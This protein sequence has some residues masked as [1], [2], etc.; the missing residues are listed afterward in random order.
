MSGIGL[1]TGSDGA[2]PRARRRTWAKSLGA[3]TLAAAAGLGVQ[4]VAAED[5]PPGPPGAAHD[6]PRFEDGVIHHSA[7]YAERIGLRVE[8]AH[9]RTLAPTTEVTGAVQRSPA[10]TAAVGALIF[11]RVR[12]VE[13]VVGQAVAAGQPLATLESAE[14][15]RAQAELAAARARTRLA[16]AEHRRKQQLVD[17]GIAAHRSVDVTGREL[18]AA[19]AFL[20]ASKQRVHA[21]LGQG[22]GQQ[23]DQQADQGGADAALGEL[24]LRTPIAGEVIAANV[25]LGQPVE[26]DE[27]AFEVADLRHLWLELAVFTND[28]PLI[29]EGDDVLVQPHGDEE[30]S[31]RGHV[32]HV[33]S[34]IDPVSRTAT[35]RV[36]VDDMARALRVGQ[37]VRAR[38]VSRGA[39]VRALA[40]P[41]HA[42]VL[43]DGAPTVFVSPAEGQV[44]PR[45]VALG[46]HGP[47]HVEVREGLRPG[48]RVVVDG[49]FELKSELFR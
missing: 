8:R 24:V 15:G 23:A 39:E 33:G 36:E 30:T 44:L 34:A 32:A 48:E 19:R 12:S 17:E 45:T 42:V 10:H 16:A 29:A 46:V 14:L 47:E 9:E 2:E 40:V 4:W 20:R 37:A 49:V 5:R 11:G 31:V 35:V 41:R 27:V 13:V 38:I 26:T 1:G 3:L 22:L 6:V 43:V 7:A 18:E 21:M 25:V 28:L